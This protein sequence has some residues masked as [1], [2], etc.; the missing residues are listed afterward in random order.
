MAELSEK[1]GLRSVEDLAAEHFGDTERALEADRRATVEAVA[2]WLEFRW[3]YGEAEGIVRVLR[4][5]LL[6]EG[7]G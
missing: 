6:S 4:R 2:Q 1:L 7:E 5:E 3:R